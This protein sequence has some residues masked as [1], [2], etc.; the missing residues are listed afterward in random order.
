[1]TTS[2]QIYTAEE[3]LRDLKAKIRNEENKL[4]QVTD[5]V[6][7]MRYRLDKYESDLRKAMRG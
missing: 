3:K 2:E 5:A 6:G 7:A 4:R 1:M